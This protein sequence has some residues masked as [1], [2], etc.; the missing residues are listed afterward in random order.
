MLQFFGAHCIYG[1]RAI[2][3]VHGHACAQNA[4]LT[5]GRLIVPGRILLHDQPLSPWVLPGQLSVRAA[6]RMRGA[7]ATVTLVG[8][9]SQTIVAWPDDTLRDFMLFDVLMHE[10]G[11]HRIQ[12]YKGNRSARVMRTRDHEASADHFAR[13]CRAQYAARGKTD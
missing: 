13:Q 2:E 10:I 12:Q 6:E 8:H 3:L 1:I 4:T 9:G 7:G 11:H 5:F